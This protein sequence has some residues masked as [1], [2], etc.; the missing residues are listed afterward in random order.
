MDDSLRTQYFASNFN[1]DLDSF[2]SQ[3][4]TSV[5]SEAKNTYPRES[6]MIGTQFFSDSLYGIPERQTEALLATTDGAG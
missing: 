6:F 5:S 4:K 1:K 2:I 3:M